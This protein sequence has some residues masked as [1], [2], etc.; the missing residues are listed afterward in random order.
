M[1]V[2]TAASATPGAWVR[3]LAWIIG[4]AASLSPALVAQEWGSGN[5]RAEAAATLEL[6]GCQ[7]QLLDS[8]ALPAVKAAK[9]HSDDLL[10]VSSPI[11]SE[12]AL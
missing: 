5:S 3:T 4:C 2:E 7:G 9:K 10:F 12:K 11:R 1:V 8:L 6:V